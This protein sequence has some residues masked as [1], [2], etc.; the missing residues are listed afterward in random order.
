M[1]EA[2]VGDVTCETMAAW[3]A[4]G[5]RMARRL[6]GRTALDAA[7]LVPDP[8][9]LIAWTVKV[10]A[11]VLVRPRTMHERVVVLVH[12]APPGVAVTV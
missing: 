1:I 10:Y 4:R 9:A 2:P 11:F 8:A 7:D 5:V 3:L 12:V 6:N